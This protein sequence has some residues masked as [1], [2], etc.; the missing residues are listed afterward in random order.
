MLRPQDFVHVTLTSPGREFRG[1]SA[2]CLTQREESLYSLLIS[3]C[4]LISWAIVAA[5]TPHL[6]CESGSP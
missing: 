5:D 6:R 3:L 1:G 4:W 2:F